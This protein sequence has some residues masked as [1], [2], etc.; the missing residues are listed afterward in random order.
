MNIED[1]GEVLVVEGINELAAGNASQVRDDVRAALKGTHKAIEFDLSDIS[2][3][4]SSGLGTLISLHKTMMGRSG[5]VRLMNP[6]PVATQVLELTR[7]HRIFE[8][9]RS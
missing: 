5:S 9:V 7:M 6:T 1:K 2:F 3:L 4:D 8:I